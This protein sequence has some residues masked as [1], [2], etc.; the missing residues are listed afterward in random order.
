MWYQYEQSGNRKRV[1]V[2]LLR[3]LGSIITEDNSCMPEVERR[4]S[5]VKQD[6]QCNKNFLNNSH[7]D[8]GIRKTFQKLLFG[9]PY[10]MEVIVALWEKVES[11]FGRSRN[12][13]LAKDE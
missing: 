2:L 6:F 9:V 10:F 4:V 8:L 3:K 13:D 7:R 12:V 11:L 1:A 5:F